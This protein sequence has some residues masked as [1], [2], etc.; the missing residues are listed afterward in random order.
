MTTPLSPGARV[1]WSS[2]RPRRAFEGHVVSVGKRTA[3]V[4]L[5]GTHKLRWVKLERLA[6]MR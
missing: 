3:H 1:A 4:R 6:V 2:W 5:T